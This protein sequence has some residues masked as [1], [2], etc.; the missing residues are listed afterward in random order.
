MTTTTISHPN[1]AFP[2]APE[3]GRVPHSS[4]HPSVGAVRPWLLRFAQ[5]PDATQATALPATLY[6]EELQISIGVDTDLLP[7]MQ[8]HSPTVPDGSTSNPP[9][10]DEGT[11][12]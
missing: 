3:G 2:L 5:K 10:L 4:E 8:T 11:K 1:E 6:D 12:D 9:P 7:Y